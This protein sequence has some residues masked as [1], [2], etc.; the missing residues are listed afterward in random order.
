MT[1]DIG[2]IRRL[3]GLLGHAW[4]FTIVGNKIAPRSL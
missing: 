2:R 3:M 4:S 1:C